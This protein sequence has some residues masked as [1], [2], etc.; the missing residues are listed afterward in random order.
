[1]YS[2]REGDTEAVKALIEAGAKKDLQNEVSLLPPQPSPSLNPLPPSL[3][4]V[5]LP[6]SLPFCVSP[7]LHPPAS[8]SPPPSPPSLSSLSLALLPAR[9]PALPNPSPHVSPSLPP[10]LSQTKL[11]PSLPL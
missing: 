6:L 2:A 3:F 7:S 11:S 8:L 5:S 9:Q 4:S 10:S 1:M